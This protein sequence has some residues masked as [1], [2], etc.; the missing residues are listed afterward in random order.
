MRQQQ[1]TNILSSLAELQDFPDILNV[2]QEVDPGPRPDWDLPVLACTAVGGSEESALLG[3]TAIACLQISII[4]VD[5][6]LD[7]DPRGEFRKRGVGQTANLALG[8]QAA[9]FRVLDNAALSDHV[10]AASLASLA[11][12]ASATSAGQNL[13]TANLEGE[14]NYWRLIRAKSTPFYGGALQIGSILG[15][16]SPLISDEFYRMGVAIGEII[17]IEDDLNDAFENPANPDW[18]EGRNNLLILYASFA[19]HS[20]R[21][22][23]ITIRSQVMDVSKLLEAQKLL[24]TSGALSYAAFTLIEKYKYAKELLSAMELK[25]PEPLEEIL[26]NY[27]LSLVA[28]LEKSGQEIPKSLIS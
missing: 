8:F 2:F 16:A 28:F 5:D 21:E 26:D 25:E 3:S 20:E 6:M 11:Y 27:A 10:R 18:L 1:I 7:N 15:G 23:F 22:K 9:A 4:L 19:D 14:E 24:I 12:I 17:Q 13:D